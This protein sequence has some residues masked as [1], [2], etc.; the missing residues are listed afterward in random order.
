LPEAVGILSKSNFSSTVGLQIV[1]LGMH[2]LHYLFPFVGKFLLEA[3]GI[4]SLSNYSWT[5]KFVCIVRLAWFALSDFSR[6][7]KF[8]LKAVF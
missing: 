6:D 8:L 5:L 7:G 2:D 4:L 1:S 3:V